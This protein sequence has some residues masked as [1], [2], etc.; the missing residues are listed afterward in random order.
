MAA[1]SASRRSL[2]A[3]PPSTVFCHYVV[4]RILEKWEVKIK[5]EKQIRYL[6]QARRLVDAF[7]KS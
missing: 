3:V 5:Q 2:L 1:P 6:S 7:S 4:V